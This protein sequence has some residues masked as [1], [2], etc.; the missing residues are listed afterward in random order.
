MRGD[1]NSPS[2]S[3]PGRADCVEN[4]PVMRQSTVIWRNCRNFQIASSRCASATGLLFF[5]LEHPA[6][7]RPHAPPLRP[8]L[9]AHPRVAGEPEQAGRKPVHRP[10]RRLVDGRPA[11]PARHSRIAGN[12]P[13]LDRAGP[14]CSAAARRAS[15]GVHRSPR[16]RR[17][18]AGRRVYAIVAGGVVRQMGGRTRW[19][20]FTRLDDR[21]PQ[22]S[23]GGKGGPRT[24]ARASTMSSPARGA[25][26]PDRDRRRSLDCGRATHQPLGERLSIRP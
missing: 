19:K 18:L 2:Q 11:R 21:A 1:T 12:R 4:A 7:R 22:P 24:T 23:D 9:L 8:S 15:A 14:S 3:E 5:Q 10:S 16:A 6:G 20:A 25:D 26:D 13:L 17:R